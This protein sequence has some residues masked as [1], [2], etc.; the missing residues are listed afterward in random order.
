MAPKAMES[1]NKHIN[2]AQIERRNGSIAWAKPGSL[3]VPV[4][5]SPNKST[6]CFHH[7]TVHGCHYDTPIA[8]WLFRATTAIRE[9]TF[10]G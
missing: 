9:I 7:E 10:A 4:P 2:R 1:S 3:H 5:Y 8:D 6:L